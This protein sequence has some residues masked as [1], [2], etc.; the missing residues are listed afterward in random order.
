MRTNYDFDQESQWDNDFGS[1]LEHNEKHE[2]Q[3]QRRREQRQH[4][5][6]ASPEVAFSN[7]HNEYAN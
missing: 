5:K 4:H 7:Y 6:R 3:K 2:R 1:D